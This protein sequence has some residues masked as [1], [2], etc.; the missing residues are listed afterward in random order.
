MFMCFSEATVSPDRQ[1]A[2]TDYTSQKGQ[3]QEGQRIYSTEL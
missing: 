1:I 2:V 3:S